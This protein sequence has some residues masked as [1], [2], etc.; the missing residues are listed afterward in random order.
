MPLAI[1]LKQVH[2]ITGENKIWIP[3]LWVY[4]P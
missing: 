3:N 2:L 4:F 1:D